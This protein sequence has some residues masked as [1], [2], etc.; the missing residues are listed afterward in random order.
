V[1]NERAERG[2][3]AILAVDL[4]VSAAAGL[5]CRL[6]R[7]ALLV[8]SRAVSADAVL[9]YLPEMIG[10]AAGGIAS[11][12]YGVQLVKHLASKHLVQIVA[13]LLAGIGILMLAEVALPFN[14]WRSCPLRPRSTSPQGSRSASVSADPRPI[15]ER[16]RRNSRNR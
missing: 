13:A 15:Q 10:L 1:T 16:E 5:L 2:L 11:A 9:P 12:S 6:S 8:R 14:M 7:P 3:T 4:A